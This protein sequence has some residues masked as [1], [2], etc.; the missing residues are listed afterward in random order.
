MHRAPADRLQ[1]AEGRGGAGRGPPELSASG[2]LPSSSEKWEH[3]PC[4]REVGRTPGP[5]REAGSPRRRQLWRSSRLLQAANRPAGF[6]GLGLGG[7]LPEVVS[8]WS[9]SVLCPG[10]ICPF[11]RWVSRTLCWVCPERVLV[12]WPLRPR[13]SKF[14]SRRSREPRRELRELCLGSPRGSNLARVTYCVWSLRSHTGSDVV[15]RPS[16]ATPRRAPWELLEQG[17][18][19]SGAKRSPWTPGGVALRS[20]TGRVPAAWA[21]CP[22]GPS[23]PGAS[24]LTFSPRPGVPSVRPQPWGSWRRGLP[25]DGRGPCSRE[26][27]RGRGLGWT[28]RTGRGCTAGSA[29]GRPSAGGLLPRQSWVTGTMSPA[30]SPGRASA[31]RTPERPL[32][33]DLRWAGTPTKQTEG[34]RSRRGSS[35]PCDLVGV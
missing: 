31:P 15:V 28:R 32:H 12:R 6:Q 30:L 18:G 23:H 34:R 19:K 24:L 8:P 3:E 22:R 21:E 35:G 4:P 1:G 20:G 27:L 2:Q 14:V 11:P 9:R 17:P 26:T 5:S 29:R 33:P 16:E 10:S 7:L 25:A 13:C